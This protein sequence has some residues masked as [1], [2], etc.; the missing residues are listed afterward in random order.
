MRRNIDN[1]DN[2]S[3]HNWLIES[4][5]GEGWNNRTYLSYATRREAERALTGWRSVE[6]L[7]Q[8]RLK[9]MK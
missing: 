8:F 9:R 6:P 4:N 7:T 1:T 2:G 5:R 3:K